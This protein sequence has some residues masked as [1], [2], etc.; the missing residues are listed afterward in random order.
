[1]DGEIT[2]ASLVVCFE[3]YDCFPMKR[4]SHSRTKT[5]MVAQGFLQRHVDLWFAVQTVEAFYPLEPMKAWEHL[6]VCVNVE[7]KVKCL[8]PKA[9]SNSEARKSWATSS[10]C[11]DSYPDNMQPTQFFLC[12]FKRLI[13]LAITEIPLFAEF[14][15]E[16]RDVKSVRSSPLS[17]RRRRFKWSK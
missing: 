8:I 16:I 15:A 11:C 4:L 13:P 6:S 1:M 5:T 10:E 12:V 2:L 7:G 3:F 14:V 17:S 9:R